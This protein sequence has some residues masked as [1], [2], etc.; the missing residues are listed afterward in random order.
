VREYRA[1][2][3][4]QGSR[5]SVATVRKA[6]WL[7]ASSPDPAARDGKEALHLAGRLAMHQKEPDAATLDLQA[8]AYAQDGDFGQAIKLAQQAISLANRAAD[9]ELA[10]LIQRRLCLYLANNPYIRLD[11]ASA[12]T[13]VPATAPTAAATT[14]AP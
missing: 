10:A 14:T 11:A 6:A 5:V 7:M 3:A 4:A 13:T 8:A 2:L 12:P 1:Y 9:R